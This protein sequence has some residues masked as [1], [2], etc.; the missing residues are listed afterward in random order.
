VWIDDRILQ[1]E[2]DDPVRNKL[3]AIADELEAQ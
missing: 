3:L 2:K 1:Y